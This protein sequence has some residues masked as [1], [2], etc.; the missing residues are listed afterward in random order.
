MICEDEEFAQRKLGDEIA[1]KLKSRL[2]DML[3]AKCVMDIPT[4]SPKAVTFEGQPAFRITIYPP[5]HFTFCS[6]HQST[7][8]DLGKLDWHQVSRIKILNITNLSL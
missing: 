8:N 1:K 7:L 3:A 2:A 5:Y 6:A 4:G